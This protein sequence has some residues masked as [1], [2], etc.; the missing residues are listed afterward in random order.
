MLLLGIYGGFNM[1]SEEFLYNFINAMSIEERIEV[2]RK[3][4]LNMNIE[5]DYYTKW[6]NRK[7]IVYKKDLYKK[8]INPVSKTEFNFAIKNLSDK[9]KKLL[10]E[11]LSSQ[12]WYTDFEEI[13]NYSLK[14]NLFEKSKEYDFKYSYRC[15]LYWAKYKISSFIQTINNYNVSSNVIEQFL[16]ALSFNIESMINKSIIVEL[17]TY[18]SNN[19]A[20]GESPE[21]RFK[22]FIKN[23]FCNTESILKFYSKYS[24]LA[25][26]ITI[27]TNYFINHVIDSLKRLNENFLEVKR[28]IKLNSNE[29]LVNVECAIGDSHNKGKSVIQF[30]FANNKKLIYK[31]RNLKII[32]KYNDFIT[33]IN[34]NSN[35]LSIKCNKGIYK[36]EFAFE[37]FVEYKECK[38]EKDVHFYY[39]KF[40]QLIA[41]MYILRGSDFHYENIIANG[42]N[43]MIIDIETIFHQPTCINIK[44]TAD[45]KAK[46]QLMSSVLGSSLIPFI[47]V[48]SKTKDLDFSGLSGDEQTLPYE[49]LVLKNN[50]TD[51]I[52]YEYSKISLKKCNN[53]PKING[54]KVNFRDFID[55]IFLGFKNMNEFFINKRKF[56]ISNKFLEHLFNN[57]IT[58]QV[59]KNT[60]SYADLLNFS[61]HPTCTTDFRNREKLLE[62]LWGY[63]YTNKEN[64]KYEYFDML[65][66]DIPIFFTQTNSRD[67]ISSNGDIIENYFEKT[68]LETSIELLANLSNEEI[69][70]QISYMIVNF[71]KYKNYCK[72]R[73]IENNKLHQNIK[74]D[75]LLN[76]I[77]LI[78]EANNIGEYI[79]NQSIICE[80]DNTITWYDIVHLEK[81]NQIMTMNES[82][83]D[84]LSGQ[85]VLFYYLFKIT[86]NEKY[87]FL[88]EKMVKS[89]YQRAKYSEDISAFYGQGALLYPLLILYKNEKHEKYKFLIDEIWKY[90]KENVSID[91]NYDWL[92]GIAGLIK[93]AVN[94]YEILDS[95]EYIEL[96][97][98]LGYQLLD[99]LRN[100]DINNILGG[101]S[102]GASGIFYS[103]NLLF[104]YTNINEFKVC[105]DKFLSHDRSFFDR[106][107]NGWIDN[108]NNFQCISKKWCHGSTGIGIS[109]I[110]FNKNNE[111][112]KE[113]AIAI[114]NNKDFLHNEDC[115]CHGNCGDIDFL[116]ESYRHD[117]NFNT[118]KIIK[119]KLNT[120]MVF[121]NITNRYKTEEIP[122]FKKLGL[123]TGISGI[124]YLLLRAKFYDEIPSILTLDI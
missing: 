38:T 76:E 99:I 53:I 40:G 80:Y 69:E 26:L 67:L 3:Y 113:I 82:L 120:I 17:H 25:R 2:F 106:T 83:Y 60:Q 92:T 102:H 32:E 10:A 9:E 24:V 107:L 78:N 84:G 50:N 121:K 14:N 35:L 101:M 12:N 13:I 75:Y 103:M 114:E 100:K 71:G 28:L 23:T 115:L 77:N 90:I 30:I 117:K 47:H 116:I 104:N 89:A 61:Y 98:L 88:I 109:R 11:N 49:V 91:N 108:R 81:N 39:Q 110:H 62:N 34:G 122:G 36:E 94:T 68:A 124:A 5:E 31:P 72:D 64:I 4:D 16:D 41:I 37:K 85:I 6:I 97:K 56:I 65:F 87:K 58:R 51:E 63:D 111:F 70:K 112:T 79:L 95:N 73:F 8:F 20:V 86:K 74:Y 52:K 19:F 59:L 22:M 119:N 29:E 45:S 118:E 46:K 1:I 55:D 33:W 27:K 54:E 105:A 48:N 123:F 93:M 57:Q 42:N 44:E 7:S 18:K 21:E 15:F 96:A 43:P 66:D